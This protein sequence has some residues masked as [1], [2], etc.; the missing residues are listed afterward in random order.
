MIKQASQSFSPLFGK[1]DATLFMPNCACIYM[2]LL[3]LFNL[4]SPVLGFK[5]PS[6]KKIFCLGLKALQ[7]ETPLVAKTDLV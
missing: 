7:G 3:C 4:L 1:Q 5:N 2:C 6:N